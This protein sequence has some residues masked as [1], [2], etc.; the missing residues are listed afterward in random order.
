M[1]LATLIHSYMFIQAVSYIRDQVD[2]LLLF[3]F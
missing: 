1:P 3:I 2:I